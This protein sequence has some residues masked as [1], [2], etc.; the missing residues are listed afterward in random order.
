MGLM[1]GGW[2]VVM[3]T[4]SWKTKGGVRVTQVW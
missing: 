4:K 2:C 3:N 1:G